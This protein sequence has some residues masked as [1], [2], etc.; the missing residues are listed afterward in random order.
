MKVAY[1]LK[2]V[3][4]VPEDDI[5]SVQEHIANV[6]TETEK[7]KELLLKDV[8]EYG[9]HLL[10]FATVTMMDDVELDAE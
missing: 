10:N 1:T 9:R 2:I 4:D 5:H 8:T 7:I 3:L 6:L